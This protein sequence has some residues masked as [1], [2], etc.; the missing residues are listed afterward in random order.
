MAQEEQEAFLRAIGDEEDIKTLV[1]GMAKYLSDPAIQQKACWR[2]WT[3]S[4]ASDGPVVGV[5]DDKK[6]VEIANLGGVQAILKAMKEHAAQANVQ[7]KA[8][9]ALYTLS[10]NAENKALIKKEGGEELVRRAMAA[11]DAT[12]NTKEY[13]Q[14]LLDRLA[15]C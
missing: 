14:K 2:L 3:L 12:D 5:R 15:Q 8:C 7:A 10:F 11:S 4:D 13:G 6:R 9:G 1:R